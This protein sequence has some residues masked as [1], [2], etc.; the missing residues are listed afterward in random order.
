MSGRRNPIAHLGDLPSIADAR[1]TGTEV[2]AHCG[3]RSVPRQ[4]DPA[5]PVHICKRCKR[6]EDT[7]KASGRG[8]AQ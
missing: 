6:I 5:L 4:F 3:F 1:V 8:G 7:L 2:T